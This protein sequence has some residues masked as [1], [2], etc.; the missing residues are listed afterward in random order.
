MDE[1]RIRDLLQE[2]LDFGRGAEEV[3]QGDLHLLG[4]VRER[5]RRLQVV[6]NQLGALFPATVDAPGEASAELDRELPRLE[7]YDVESVIGRGGMGVVFKALHRKLKR[8]VAVKM[9]LA[10]AYA[11]PQEL[12]RFRREAEAVASLRHPNIV[13]VYDVGSLAGR[14]YFTMEFVEHGNLAQQLAESPPP[15]RQAA[16][17]TATLADAVQCA[18]DGAVIHRDLKPSNILLTIDGAPK[19]ADFGLARFADGNPEFTLSGARIGTPNYMAPEQALGKSDAI[20]PA[21]D[22]YA[23]GA[24]LYE[25]LTGWPPF[26]ADSAAET[27]RRL[28]TEEPT[29]PSR[30]RSTVSRDLETICLKCLHKIPARR[31]A[32]A[33]DLAEDLR[34]YL[35]G[36]PV[37]AR[38]AGVAERTVMWARRRPA[39]AALAAALLFAFGT[40]VVTGIYFD[41]RERA[42]QQATR[43]SVDNSVSRT[44]VLGHAERWHDADVVVSD[45]ANQLGDATILENKDLHA[46]IAQV[47]SDLKFAEQLENIRQSRASSIVDRTYIQPAGVARLEKEYAAAFARAG[48]LVD[49]DPDQAAATIRSSAFAPQS[50]VALDEW[51]FTA[52]SLDRESLHSRLLRIARI[53]DPDSA[54][55]DRFRDAAAW[56]SG[57]DLVKLTRDASGS[58]T[59]P[60]AHQLAILGV[61]LS[62]SGARGQG[63]PLLR[64]ALRHRPTDFWLNWEMGAA[65]LRDGKLQEAA[66]YYRIVM[67]MR[68]ESSWTRNH[69][70]VRLV[71]A[72]QV[73]EGI[74]EIRQ[75]VALDPANG[76][77]R[78][79]LPLALVRFGRIDEALAECRRA[80]EVDPSSVRA[81]FTF[82]TVLSMANRHTEA[83]AMYR[84]SVDLDPGEAP[85]WCNLGMA[86]GI[87]GMFDEAASAFRKTIELEPTSVRGHHG[88]GQALRSLRKHEEALPEF[89]KLFGLLEPQKGLANSIADPES[90][91]MVA[92]ACESWAE[93]L[94]LL[95]RF[96]EAHDASQR[97]LALPRIGDEQRKKLL[98]Q[99][100]LCK[101]LRNFEGRM[102]AL[103]DSVDHAEDVAVQTALAEWLYR[104]RLFAAVR[105]YKSLFAKQPALA[106]DPSAQHRWHAACAASLA[107]TGLCD[108]AAGLTDELRTALRAQ[109]FDWLKADLDAWS[110]RHKS[111]R[112]ADQMIAAAAVRDW[113][114]NADLAPVRDDAFL[115]KLPEKTR[116]EWLDLWA[117]VN[118]LAA[119]DPFRTLDQGR[120]RVAKKRWAE[121]I[122]YYKHSLQETQTRDGEIGFEYAALQ[123]LTEDRQGYRDTFRRMLDGS[124]GAPTIRPYLL[125][126]T[127][128]LAP[129]SSDDANRTS[130]TAS[131]EL[132][133]FATTFWS[134]TQQAALHCRA[135]R[136][137][138]AV[139][140]LERSLQ[141]EPK[142]GAAVVN[143]L[144]LALAYRESG[145]EEEARR[146][147]AKG[148]SWLDSLGDEMPANADA[149]GLHRHNWLEAHVLRREAEEALSVPGS[150]P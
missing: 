1:N 28:I 76:V 62:R 87:T 65:L 79:N 120:D 82:G 83:I 21:V 123:L 119:R 116:L 109:A 146:W 33:R 105:R 40:A 136:P 5:W 30:I 8:V 67:T 49:G 145:Q 102:P 149:V 2:M 24:V 12:A 113:Q 53:A 118:A 41:H 54:W 129:G 64:E 9:L 47:R 19:I 35:D 75:A 48:I 92:M 58:P 89:E 138:L 126:R 106:N 27:Q 14:P 20:G 61:L 112:P 85:T 46:R 93:S 124:A 148:A 43:L 51:A 141:A 57:Q 107:S 133:R 144:W 103:L 70:G 68:P 140:L 71:E 137:D 115:R 135:D 3:C 143:W 77:A 55:R 69:L 91:A 17:L 42:H 32:T 117:S 50:I 72:G 94:C 134:L 125:A 142:P 108:D 16:E 114:H 23:L 131:K 31:Y 147:L 13:Q 128:T 97:A 39:L 38:P 29:P 110:N 4:A 101:R 44:V 78:R 74:A 60:P 6:G 121:A 15:A 139:P 36:R 90:D 84:K 150:S 34:R 7:G 66:T 127:C 104:K 95:G 80:V 25:M 45:A 130:R 11:G 100:D 86:L 122:E 22:I 37:H 73:E 56:R 98:R 111:G 81:A 132:D 10:G 26:R 63:V 96:G 59:P 99:D 18:H 52:F 88:L